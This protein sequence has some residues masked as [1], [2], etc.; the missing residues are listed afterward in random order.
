MAICEQLLPPMFCVSLAFIA[1]VIVPVTANDIRAA[2][3]VALHWPPRAV[4]R[5]EDGAFL[6]EAFTSLESCRVL[7]FKV[8]SA[9]CFGFLRLQGSQSCSSSFRLAGILGFNTRS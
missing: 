6:G 3:G 8:R 9:G 5:T 7:G 4:Y 2:A 1:A